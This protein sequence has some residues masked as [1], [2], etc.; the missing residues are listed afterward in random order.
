[1]ALREDET[2]CYTSHPELRSIR[3]GCLLEQGVAKRQEAPAL[4]PLLSVLRHA[5]A[6]GRRM[7]DEVKRKSG[8][9]RQINLENNT[10]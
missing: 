6:N 9:R 2:G 3:R 7:T 1:M 8:D 4:R 5:P 10:T